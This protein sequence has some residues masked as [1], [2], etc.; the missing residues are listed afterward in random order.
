MIEDKMCGGNPGSN[1]LQNVHAHFREA[2]MIY[3]V[4][5]ATIGLYGCP[6]V[7]K[8]DDLVRKR[9]GWIV[10]ANT[11]ES[12][13]SVDFPSEGVFNVYLGSVL[14]AGFSLYLCDAKEPYNPLQFFTKAATKRA[15][16]TWQV[17]EIIARLHALY[18][19][20][21]ANPVLPAELKADLNANLFGP[22]TLRDF[23]ENL[24]SK[25]AAEEFL[26]KVGKQFQESYVAFGY[27]QE[28]Y[29]AKDPLACCQAM[30]YRGSARYLPD[31]HPGADIMLP[32]VVGNDKSSQYGLVLIQVKGWK[33]D[34]LAVD[35]QAID[36]M[37]KCTI[38]GV[39]GMD[40]SDGRLGM[41]TRNK[42]KLMND[43]YADFPVVRILLNYSTCG[44][45][46][47]NGSKVLQDKHGPFILM[48]S[49]AMDLKVF[50]EEVKNLCNMAILLASDSSEGQLESYEAH[51]RDPPIKYRLGPFN[52]VYS[53][54][55][56]DNDK[57]VFS[58][59][60]QKSRLFDKEADEK[61]EADKIR[62]NAVANLLQNRPKY[63]I[64]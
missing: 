28:C 13:L 64:K 35:S 9:M 19:V 2:D 12:D 49:D 61:I 20:K 32:L 21:K 51:K 18:C 53:R 60:I 39:F 62:L 54:L 25:E 14:M 23:L 33:T 40:P 41:E 47:H 7:V 1:L 31:N 37:K 27:F 4:L 10:E 11:E 42:R 57:D 59:G 8:K 43:F 48:Q 55:L 34:L 17:T 22:R 38:Q 6:S 5:S 30:L 44:G 58:G 3:A 63:D 24:C 29:E 15:F 52:P 46:P 56:H 26:K 50:K 16:A 36:A 45:H